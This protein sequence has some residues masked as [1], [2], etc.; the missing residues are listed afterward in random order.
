MDE[1]RSNNNSKKIKEVGTRVWKEFGKVWICK[2]EI[3]WN[4]TKNFNK[5]RWYIFKSPGCVQQKIK[6]TSV[7]TEFQT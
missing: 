2:L 7:L 5:Q 1:G 3:S 4:D 6:V